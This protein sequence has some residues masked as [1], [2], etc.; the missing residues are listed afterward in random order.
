MRLNIRECFVEENNT[1]IFFVYVQRGGGI[2]MFDLKI[3]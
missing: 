2:G 3:R 1:L